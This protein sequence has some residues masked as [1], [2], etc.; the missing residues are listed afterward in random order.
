MRGLLFSRRAIGL[1]TLA[2]AAAF[3]VPGAASATIVYEHAGEIWAMNDDGSGQQPLVT[4]G[5]LGMDRGLGHPHVAPNG[6]TVV[7][8]GSTNRNYHTCSGT[9]HYG[10]GATGVYALSGGQVTRLTGDPVAYQCGTDFE[11]EP[12]ATTNGR[13][14][15]GFFACSGYVSGQI[16]SYSCLN[17]IWSHAV[18]G[19]GFQELPSCSGAGSPSPNP[20]DPSEFASVGCTSGSPALTR[21]VGDSHTVVSYDDV[22]QRDP[23]WRPD[24]QRLLTAEDG[25]TPGI[26]SYD[27]TLATG[28]QTYVLAMPGGTEFESPRYMGGNSERIVFSAGGQI[29]SIPATCGVPEPNPAPCS[30]PG[31]ATQLTQSGNNSD[32]A[33]TAQGTASSMGPMGG[34]PS[35]GSPNP[36]PTTPP[37][38]ANTVFSAPPRVAGASRRRGVAFTLRLA[39][40]AT[41]LITIS[42][43]TGKSRSKLVAARAKRLG[44]V[45]FTGKAGANTFRV[46]K[47]RGKKLARG[48]YRAAIVA[49]EGS[50]RS[51]ARV[52]SFKIKR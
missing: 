25:N 32:P 47:V 42:R 18:G 3:A 20:A 46:K 19:G 12:E 24:G 37:P 38:D 13:V 29:W 6:T 14:D 21:S 11:T 9:L 35:G 34:Q 16:A 50:E 31:D 4:P 40:P 17:R 43:V 15:Y 49:V 8:D 28:S 23:S 7:F 48:R 45:R 2:V 39:R 51:S 1:A 30:F 33:W 52:V 10:L 26:W 36:N 44:T 5:P 41:V 22:D 27:R